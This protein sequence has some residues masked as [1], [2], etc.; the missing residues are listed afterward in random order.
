MIAGAI[1]LGIKRGGNEAFDRFDRLGDIGID[2]D[3]EAEEFFVAAAH[4]RQCAV[5]RHLG[6][7]LGVIEIVGE[8]GAGLFL[9]LADLG[10]QQRLVAHIGAQLAQQIGVF[11]EAF[12][13]DVTGAVERFLGAGHVFGD[14]SGSK[15]GRVGIAVA[16][17][18]LG[19]RPQAALAGDG[20]L[21]AALGLERQVE[22]FQ[23]GLRARTDNGDSQLRRQLALFING[24][25]D[26]R[27][28]RFQLPQIAQPLGQQAQLRV[29]EATRHF[30]A[31]AG[32][33]RHRRPAIEQ[34]DSRLHLGRAGRDFGGDLIGNAGFKFGHESASCSGGW[35]I[36]ASGPRKQHLSD[37][38]PIT[39]RRLP[40]GIE[41]CAYQ[42]G[43]CAGARFAIF[44]SSGHLAL[45][46][47]HRPGRVV[48]YGFHAPDRT[49]GKTG[50]PKFF[51]GP[52]C[53]AS[54]LD[55]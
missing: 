33:K 53:Q 54:W 10:A 5:A 46:R 22:I 44:R 40:S 51:F 25:D 1:A 50:K 42:F 32:D 49:G 2:F 27:A 34:F 24:F 35:T 4:H 52:L 55:P 31:V 17:N 23:I 8:L 36:G 7:K 19:Q 20:G 21:G 43:A 11:A 3:I 26:G 30:L 13:D 14:K 48:D 9:A 47:D 29:V 41:F 12:D 18:G 39:R 38:F 6:P 37:R 15:F 28:P 16:K 45:T